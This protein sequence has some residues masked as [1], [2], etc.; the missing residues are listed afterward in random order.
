MMNKII[1]PAIIIIGLIALICIVSAAYIVDETNQVVITQ[2]GEPIGDAIKE[3]GL[4]F[5]TP[6]IQRVNYFDKRLLSWDG[7]PNRIP[8]EDKK[9]IWIDTTARWKIVDPLRFLQTVRDEMGAQTRLDD[10][11]D[12]ATRNVIAKHN[13]IEIVRDTNRILTIEKSEEDKL[14]GREFERIPKESGR[15]LIIEEMLDRAKPKVSEYGIELVDMRI[16]RINYDTQVRGKV[17]ERMISERKRAAE[18]LRAEGQ[19]ERQEIEGKK[20]KEL[21]RIHSEAYHKAQVIRGKAD[22]EAIKIY[23]NA[24][25]KDPEFFSFLRTLESYHSTFDKQSMLILS[26]DS[27]YFKYL[28]DIAAE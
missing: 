11:L 15:A 5:K 20:E 4:K 13:L 7:Y 21:Q 16:K 6:F 12:G 22:A 17:F 3:P 8:T 14:M 24:Y 19:G 27:E 28:K 1:G 23:A 18:Q 2:F 10:I 26:T 9:Y 25:S